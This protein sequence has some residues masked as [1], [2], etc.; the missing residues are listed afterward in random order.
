MV[1]FCLDDSHKLRVYPGD[2]GQVRHAAQGLTLAQIL[3]QIPKK[4]A[5]GDVYRL[6]ITLTAS[7]LQLIETPWWNGAW[8]KSA[9]MFT[10]MGPS[11]TGNIDI[12][13]PLLVRDFAPGMLLALRS[14]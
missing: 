12:K 6:A 3:P 8:N 4:L 1:G 9:I 2:L 7:V 11:V 13:Y 5:N 10:R 14:Y